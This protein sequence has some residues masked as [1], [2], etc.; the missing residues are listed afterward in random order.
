MISLLKILYD[1]LNRHDKLRILIAFPVMLL[2]SLIDLLSI[3]LLVPLISLVIIGD[4][5]LPN[6]LSIINF[7][8]TFLSLVLSIFVI[9]LCK[10]LYGFWLYFWI[11][12]LTM[13]LRN[14]IHLA[15]T[16]IIFTHHS[17]VHKL[18]TREHLQQVATNEVN[19]LHL[20]I[21]VP[22]FH[23]AVDGFVVLI[24]LFGLIIVNAR[25]TLFVVTI[26]SVIYMVTRAFTKSRLIEYGSRRK[27]IESQI[28]ESVINYVRGT[29][30][31]SVNNFSNLLINK[32]E[33]S[34]TSLKSVIVPQLALLQI[35]KLLFEFGI[36][37]IVCGMILLRDVIAVDEADFAASLIFMIG[38]ASRILPS[39]NRLAVANQNLASGL[40]SLQ[41]IV[42]LFSLRSHHQCLKIEKQDSSLSQDHKLIAMS[43]GVMNINNEIY[44]RYP[45]FAIQHGQMVCITGS[46]GSGKSTLLKLMVNIEELSRGTM[47]NNISNMELSQFYLPQTSVLFFDNLIDNIIMDEKFDME[48][49]ER[50]CLAAEIDFWDLREYRSIRELSGGQQ[51]RVAIARALYHQPNVLLMDEALSAV[52]HALSQ[53][54]LRN[55][56]NFLPESTIIMVTHDL[57]VTKLFD[58]NINL[59]LM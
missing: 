40:K 28:L 53:K 38:A 12:N 55:I 16:K 10:T 42:E 37:L 21:L 47:T 30:E 50:V 13:D 35:P 14:K 1:Q 15:L 39:V 59:D 51:Q 17:I 2:N 54:I 41:A 22:I 23:L 45:D 11:N 6:F 33:K 9:F 46:S 48:Y 49:L 32:L 26:L 58:L 5:I 44:K 20:R 34:L 56:R 25:A 3:G 29:S 52:G 7:E 8:L 43:D 18:Y 57:E 27:L 31:A 36:V 24:L 4:E 19:N